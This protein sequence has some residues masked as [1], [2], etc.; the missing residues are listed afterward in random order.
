VNERPVADPC[1]VLLR[2][3]D[4]TG[5]LSLPAL[6]TRIVVGTWTAERAKTEPEKEY[7]PMD[8]D[9]VIL[10]DGAMA[11]Q[12]KHFLLGAGWDSIFAAGFPLSYPSIGVAVRLRGARGAVAHQHA[13]A[14]D[15][16]DEDDRS[17]LP[18]PPGPLQATVGT[19]QPPEPAPGRD[20]VLCVAFTLAG[21]TFPRPGP[22]AVVVR[23]DG[24]PAA[25]SPFMV[26]QA[27]TQAG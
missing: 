15:V 25:Q 17:I 12:G 1:A 10:A 26:V 18:N 3:T 11:V 5:G 21:V 14:I 4:G 7:M 9:Y 23:L 2:Q 16:V 22:Y 20:F 19:E 24:E 27:P 13:L 6:T 8:I